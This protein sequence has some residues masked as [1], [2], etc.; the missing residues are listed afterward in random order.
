MRR[1]LGRKL[2]ATQSGDKFIK[3]FPPSISTLLTGT[4]KG[5]NSFKFLD[6][7]QLRDALCSKIYFNPS[8]VV[9]L[10]SDINKTICLNII[11]SLYLFVINIYFSRRKLS[12]FLPL[13]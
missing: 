4:I 13:E 2:P 6:K 10:F 7:P 8:K 3:I 1:K 12:I 11:K 9:C 5:K